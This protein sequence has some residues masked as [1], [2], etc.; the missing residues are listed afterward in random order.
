MHGADHEL[1]VSSTRIGSR[2]ELRQRCE[3]V[4]LTVEIETRLE[5]VCVSDRSEGA[6]PEGGDQEK[7]AHGVL[8]LK[9]PGLFSVGRLTAKVYAPKA[10]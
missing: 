6:K 10:L 9:R 3:V 5:A 2:A 4:P 1:S 7:F 8:S